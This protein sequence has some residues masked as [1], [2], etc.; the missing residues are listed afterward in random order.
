MK[1]PAI[2]LIGAGFLWLVAV[3]VGFALVTS[4]E[5]SWGNAAHAP[6][7]WPG[8]TLIDLSHKRDSV[9]I[10]A[11]PGCPCTTATIEELNQ[12]MC[13]RGS[14][15][16]A[17]VLLMTPSIKPA[18]WSESPLRNRAASIKGVKVIA[19]IDGAESRRFGASTS[20][21]V[22]LFGTDEQLL[23]SGGI[24]GS[25]GHVGDNLGLSGLIAALDAR[26]EKT[27]HSPVFGCQLHNPAR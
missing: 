12:L 22:L 4:Y 1:N 14:K 2:K 15:V 18:N 19:D 13:K 21:Q 5:N 9:L 27:R 10:F 17:Y 8:S 7:R 23:F 16:D 24:T 6:T 3:T 11:H 26:S 25:R 20:G